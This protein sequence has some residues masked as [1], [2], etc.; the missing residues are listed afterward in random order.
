MFSIFNRKTLGQWKDLIFIVPFMI[1]FIVWFLGPVIAGLLLS[2]TNWDILGPIEFVGIDNYERLFYDEIFMISFRNTVVFAISMVFVGCLVSFGFALAVHEVRHSLSR[3]F[4]RSAFFLPVV[5]PV[6]AVSV[7]W[8]WMLNNQFGF[9]NHYLAQMGLP[10]PNWLGVSSMALFSI[11][12]TT[13][14]WTAG[15][16]MVIFLASLED[17]PRSYLEASIIDGATWLQQLVKIRLPLIKPIILFVLVTSTIS[18]LKVFAQAYLMTQ[19]G[20]G[21]STMTVVYHL[22]NNAFR[23]FKVGYGSAIAYVLVL[24]M[25]LVALVQFKILGWGGKES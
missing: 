14:W 10:T 15:L 7:I 5:L 6:S 24:V 23:F 2:F 9:V 3:T 8:T 17:I 21:H 11:I 12:G 18:H 19:G 4:F 1:L 22:Y 13:I 25:I 20:P 16:N